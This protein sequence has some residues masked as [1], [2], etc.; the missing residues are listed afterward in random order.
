[1][2]MP[3]ICTVCAAVG[4]VEVDPHFGHYRDLPNAAH[5]GDFV[6]QPGGWQWTFTTKSS[7]HDH[8]Y[9][10]SASHGAAR[11]AWRT[12]EKPAAHLWTAGLLLRGLKLGLA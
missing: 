2:G 4:R 12:I 9:R 7:G 8:V 10:K 6:R 1:M 5:D 11:H 3:Q